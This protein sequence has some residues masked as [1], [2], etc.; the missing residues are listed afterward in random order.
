MSVYTPGLRVRACRDRQRRRSYADSVP[1]GSSRG[2]ALFDRPAARR[3][4]QPPFTNACISVLNASSPSLLARLRSE[5]PARLFLCAI[6][7]AELLFGARRSARPAINL[8][9]L[10]RFFEPFASLPLDDRCADRY[11]VIREELSRRGELIGPNDLL[12]A[13][14]AL[15]NDLV[16]VTN[17]TAEF[18][19]VSGLR[20]EDWEED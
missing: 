2:A 4:F 17:N 14:T 19:R 12:I 9:L 13:A 10:E 20:I 6:V 16:L 1:R 8:R 5:D 11:A 3:A 7:K 18:E 15:A